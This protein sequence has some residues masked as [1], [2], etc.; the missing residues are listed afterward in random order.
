MGACSLI[1]KKNL[2]QVLDNPTER[3]STRDL[4]M[5]NDNEMEHLK[6]YLNKNEKQMIQ[7]IRVIY[8]VLINDNLKEII[9][10]RDRIWPRQAKFL[11][12]SMKYC[13]SLLIL[14]LRNNDLGNEGARIVSLS[15]RFTPC[16]IKLIIE[17]NL[18]KESGISYI[19]QNLHNLS[20]LEVMS[21]SQNIMGNSME[22]FAN[23]LTFLG[24][25]KEL[26]LQIMEINNNDF[27]LLS[28][29]LGR[30]NHLEKLGLGHNRMDV[31]CLRALDIVIRSLK[32][33]KSL[34]ISGINL[35]EQDLDDLVITNM[36][37]SI[38]L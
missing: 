11:S 1:C 38:T 20:L 24:N 12:V 23:S 17:D 16:L 35:P 18:I 14:N 34:I 29:H 13:P 3:I 6:H 36:N 31:G 15:F 32:N 28:L 2:D 19:S 8:S 30:C 21:L 9:L 27:T 5:A 7:K 26:Y 4:H 33:L 10:I 37:I 22:I 25:L